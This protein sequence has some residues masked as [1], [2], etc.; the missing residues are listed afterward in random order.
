MTLAKYVAM[1]RALQVEFGAITSDNVEQV[2]AT[3][4]VDA[5]DVVF[6]DHRYCRRGSDLPLFSHLIGHHFHAP[7]S[8]A[9]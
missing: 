3:F 1:T 4:F 9:K 7:V 5:K 8:S 6:I 2:G